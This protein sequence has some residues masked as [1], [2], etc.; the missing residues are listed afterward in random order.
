MKNIF[1][2]IYK[3]HKWFGIPLAVMFIMWYVSGI[4]KLYHQFPRLTPSTTPVEEVSLASLSE[5]W[6]EV[7]DT[8]STC[9]IFFSGKKPLVKAGDE[10]YGAFTPTSGDLRDIASSFRIQVARVDTL[11]DI[12]KWIP[13]NQLMPHLP[14]YR[15]VGAD[16]SYTYVSS[17]TGEVVGRNTRVGRAWAWIG[18]LPHYVYI[19]PI[20]RDVGLWRDVVIWMSGLS[21]L[22]VIFGLLVAV[23]FVLKRRSMHVFKN[24][25]WPLHYSWGLVF[26]LFMLAFIFSGM[27]SLAK[28]PDWIIRPAEMPEGD[29][30][31]VKA[32]VDL[33]LLPARMSSARITASPV[34]MIETRAGEETIITSINRCQPLDFSP[35]AMRPV[36]ER[37]TVE[38]VTGITRVGDDIFYHAPVD[39]YRAVTKH[40]TV[41]WNDRGFFR[42]FDAKGK[43]QAICYRFL[44]TMDIPGLNRVEWLHQIFMWVVL[45]GGLVITVTGTVLSV[46]ACRRHH[47]RRCHKTYWK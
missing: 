4:V 32:N 1:S 3:C 22:S 37:T 29:E 9:R 39:G 31:I 25:W 16:D 41:Y 10:T 2:F 33:T 27:M 8:F 14:I 46:R 13:F 42:V 23:R 40:F 19:T 44:H 18:A 11:A 15:V 38:K 26:G 17:K 36:V 7:P 20:R 47:K 28:I 43:A 24:R 35:E 45:L 12:D 30:M 5:V 6:K 34:R 21:T